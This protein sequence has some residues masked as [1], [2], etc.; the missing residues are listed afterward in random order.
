MLRE[1][2]NRGGSGDGDVQANDRV[3]SPAQKL[4]GYVGLAID[5]VGRQLGEHVSLD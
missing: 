5:D 3:A 1:E 4:G 2:G